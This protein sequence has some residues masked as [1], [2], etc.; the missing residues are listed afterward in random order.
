M[1][2]HLFNSLTRQ[3]ELFAP[4]KQGQIGMYVCGPTVYDRPH[5]GNARAVV[6]YDVLYSLLQHLFPDHEVNYVRNI[7]DVDDKIN[8]RARELNISIQEL[9]K[10]TTA[11]FHEDMGYLSC[12]KPVQEPKATDHIAEMIHIIEKLIQLGH[13]Y[14]DKGHVYFDIMSYEQNYTKLSGRK[15]EDMLAGA[16]IDIEEAKKH[17]GDFVLWKPAANDEDIAASFD[18]PWGKGRPGWHIECSAMSFKYLGADFDIHGGGAD[19]IFPHHTNEIAQ[20]KCAFPGSGHAKYWIHNGFLTVEGQKMSKSLGNFITVD[21]LRSKG[22]KGEVIR[23]ILLNTHYKKPLD[24]NENI[25]QEAQKNMDYLYRALG[26]SNEVTG[27][28]DSEFIQAL[29]DDLNSSAALSRLH[30]M[31]KEINKSNDLNEKIKIANSIK[32]SGRLLGLLNNGFA[33]WFKGESHDASKIE[34]LI[35]QRSQAKKDK[36]W[37][38]ADLIRS[39]LDD[40]GVIIE[41]S[42]AGTSWRRKG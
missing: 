27:V 35:E 31:V 4:I 20:S 2:L 22:V 39:E 11:E 30:D 10:K 12:A 40:M 34:A 42:T 5:I 37:S 17:P 19:L 13:A 28:I 32:V 41:D 29:S 36:D 6:V 24:Y 25:L 15:I 7:T 1:Q 38:K 3:K 8:I 26:Y 16:R 18:S 23:Y 9:T 14:E 21:D 33:E